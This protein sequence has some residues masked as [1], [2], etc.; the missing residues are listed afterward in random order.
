MKTKILLIALTILV[1]SCSQEAETENGDVKTKSQTV[2][3]VHPEL[4]SF[5]ST[6]RIIGN[7][8]QTKK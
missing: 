5:T 6:L 1:V 3:V 2:K 8:K 4:K 7:A